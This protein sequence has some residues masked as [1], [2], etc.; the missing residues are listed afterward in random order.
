MYAKNIQNEHA[1]YNSEQSK[2]FW[3]V[4]MKIII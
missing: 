3:E 1:I 2:K 4:K